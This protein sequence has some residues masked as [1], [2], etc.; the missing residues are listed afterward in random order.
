MTNKDWNKCRCR[1]KKLKKY[2][3]DAEL[4]QYAALRAKG[5]PIGSGT[6]ESAIRRV[7]NLRIKGPGLFWYLQNAEKMVFLRS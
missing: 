3:G 2:F 1:V 7:I 4:F 6:V 5:I